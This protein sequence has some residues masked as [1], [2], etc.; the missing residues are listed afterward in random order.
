MVTLRLFVGMFGLS[1]GLVLL[2][3]PEGSTTLGII[4]TTMSAILISLQLRVI[5]IADKKREQNENA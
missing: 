4:I 2:F 1:C 5:Y 3:V